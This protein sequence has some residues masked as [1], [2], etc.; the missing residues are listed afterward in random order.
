MRIDL[1]RRNIEELAKLVEQN[2]KAS[3][4]LRRRLLE[5]KISQQEQPYVAGVE[6]PGAGVRSYPVE[7]TALPDSTGRIDNVVIANVI[8]ALDR[9]VRLL[10]PL[11]R[12]G[13][14]PLIERGKNSASGMMNGD[15]PGRA[16]APGTLNRGRRHPLLPRAGAHLRRDAFTPERHRI[17]LLP[18]DRGHCSHCGQGQAG[19]DDPTETKTN[20]FF[21]STLHG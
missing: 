21:P 10:D 1:S 8:P 4:L 6:L 3:Q 17:R 2:S 15:H 12:Q 18:Q 13:G 11:D 9:H 19:G 7:M 14:C 16:E 5:I 20:L